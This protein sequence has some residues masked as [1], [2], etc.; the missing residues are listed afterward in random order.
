MRYTESPE[1]ARIESI[2]HPS[3][4]SD[5]SEVAFAHALKIAL[6]TKATLRMLHVSAGPDADWSDFPGVRSTLERW[7]L[8]PKGSSKSAV[9]RL[10]IDVRKVTAPS[11]DPVKACLAYLAERPA[12]LIVLAVRQRQGRMRWLKKS[13][14]EPIARGAGETT[15]FIPHGVEGFVSRADGSVSLRSILIPLARKPRAQPALDAAARLVHN[16]RLGAGT[17]TLLHVGSASEAPAVKVPSGTGWSWRR[18][19]KQGEPAEVIPR[20]AEEVAADLIMMTSDGPDGFLDGLRGTT[21]ERVLRG[22]RCPVANLPVGSMLVA[23]SRSS[24]RG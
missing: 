3:D 16:L 11:D 23:T 9:G 13:V 8:I 7:K 22:S 18:L 1:A 21:S 24:G 12:D 15:L 4:F 6:V 17:V 5:A 14:G 19:A 10:G 20:T 2:F